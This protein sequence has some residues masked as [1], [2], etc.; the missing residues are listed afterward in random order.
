[1]NAVQRKAMRRKRALHQAKQIA[2]PKVKSV[3]AAYGIDFDRM[4]LQKNGHLLVWDKSGNPHAIVQ[5]E[6]NGAASP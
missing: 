5:R 3:C 2:K 4:E 1:M 6:F